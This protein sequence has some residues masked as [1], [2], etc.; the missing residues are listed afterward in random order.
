MAVGMAVATMGR[1]DAAAG[2][3]CAGSD[4]LPDEAWR[5]ITVA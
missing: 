1:D 4:E 5:E 2:E 3:E